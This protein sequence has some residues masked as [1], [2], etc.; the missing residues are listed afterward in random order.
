MSNGNNSPTSYGCTPDGLKHLHTSLGAAPGSGGSLATPNNLDS[1]AGTTSTAGIA[2]RPQTDRFR[3]DSAVIGGSGGANNPIEAA[4]SYQHQHA[5]HEF[6]NH[7]SSHRESQGNI[8]NIPHVSC[9]SIT[10]NFISTSDQQPL[11]VDMQLDRCQYHDQIFQHQQQPPHRSQQ[12]QMALMKNVISS[13]SSNVYVKTTSFM[14]TPTTHD[15]HQS[16][17]DNDNPN[18]TGASDCAGCRM[19][20]RGAAG[21]STSQTNGGARVNTNTRYS[22]SNFCGYPV[23]LK[24]LGHSFQAAARPSAA[25]LCGAGEPDSRSKTLSRS[26]RPLNSTGGLVDVGCVV[27]ASSSSYNLADTARNWSNHHRP[28]D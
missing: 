20:A 12:P 15:Q 11:I 5:N 8:S 14:D 23:D 4:T 21:G 19:A 10:Q 3:F 7:Q 24:S 16:S 9:S 26:Y 13:P 27:A 28:P 2:Y 6:A 1:S 22:L 18:Q 17:V 25:G